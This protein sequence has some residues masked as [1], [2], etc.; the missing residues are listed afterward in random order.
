MGAPENRERRDQAKPACECLRVSCGGLGQQGSATGTGAQAAAVLGG[1]VSAII[2]LGGGH[3][4][5]FHVMGGV[6]HQL[7]AENWI[8][9][10]G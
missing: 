3:H 7:S 8:K 6:Q 2:P 9:N 1:K 4:Y 10:M 5:L